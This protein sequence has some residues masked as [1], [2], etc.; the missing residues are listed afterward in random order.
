MKD[1]FRHSI[2]IKQVTGLAKVCREYSLAIRA[3]FCTL[4]EGKTANNDQNLTGRVIDDKKENKKA[5][6]H[7]LNHST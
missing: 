6:T 3:F 7:G 4:S 1:L 5:N 2:V